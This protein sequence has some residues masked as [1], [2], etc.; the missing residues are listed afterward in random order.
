MT[1]MNFLQLEG[2]NQIITLNL[3]LLPPAERRTQYMNGS[4]AKR[5]YQHAVM[6]SLLKKGLFRGVMINKNIT[7]VSTFLTLAQQTTS[8]YSQWNENTSQ[9]LNK[10]HDSDEPHGATYPEHSSKRL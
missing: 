3:L 5:S 9:F 8:S 2:L 1:P 4:G 10:P 7:N 6:N